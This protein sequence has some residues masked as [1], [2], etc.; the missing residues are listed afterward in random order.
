[1]CSVHKEA[2]KPRYVYLMDDGY[3]KLTVVGHWMTSGH[4]IPILIHILREYLQSDFTEDVLKCQARL[5]GE[6]H[7]SI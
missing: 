3:G 4:V 6:L 2:I 1:M 7:H 5:L